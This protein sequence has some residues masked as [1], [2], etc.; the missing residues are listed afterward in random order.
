MLIKTKL[1]IRKLYYYFIPPKV[2]T[3][4]NKIR[5]CILL[6]F[7]MPFTDRENYKKQ[8]YWATRKIICGNDNWDK[9]F[10]VLRKY[11]KATGLLSC[12]LSMLGQLE[13]I[14]KKDYIPVV[15][16]KTH[17]YALSHNSPDDVGKINAWELYFEPLTTY[18]ID[19]V[20]KSKN[21]VLGYGFTTD[22]AL[23]FFNEHNI[24]R[25][26]ITRWSDLNEKYI[27]LIA[28]LQ[29]R[30]ENT[31]K[32]ILEGKRVLGVMVREGYIVL[33]QARDD[34]DPLYLTHPGIQYHPMQPSVA[35]LL[36]DIDYRMKKWNCN[37]VFISA[38]TNY[39]LN[40]LRDRFGCNVLY[41][42]RRRREIKAL[43]LEEFQNSKSQLLSDK[44][45]EQITKD[46]LE[47]IY[48]L[49]RCTSLLS[50]KCSGSVVAS[51]WNNNAYEQ[52]EFYN[53]GLY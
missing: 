23:L 7:F 11:P 35:K 24:S 8:K 9:T 17:Y 1:F 28:P 26:D 36:S 42:D 12:Y 13:I 52:M 48:L 32:K 45:V 46:Y 2:R 39:I 50:G 53:I 41:T 34:K 6:N 43:T 14:N 22:N 31:Y 25:E 47:E 44:T 38:E 18:T 27:R 20:Y 49:S 3:K 51:I 33:A 29:E 10:Y 4:I 5:R 37:F 40:V 30:F 15:D 21:V 16:M 19:D